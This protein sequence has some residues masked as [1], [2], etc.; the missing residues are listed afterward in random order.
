MLPCMILLCAFFEGS[1]AKHAIQTHILKKT[2]C[3]K[4]CEQLE[5][6][7]FHSCWQINCSSL[8]SKWRGCLHIQV[9]KLQNTL[10][11]TLSF[12]AA[13]LLVQHFRSSISLPPC[14]SISHWMLFA[15]WCVLCME[16]FCFQFFS[17]KTENL[18]LFW[19]RAH[20]S[21]ASGC[22]W[23]QK[24]KHACCSCNHRGV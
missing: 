4:T 18:K 23:K 8:I 21:D 5:P 12:P 20:S 15:C 2:Q 9:F 24:Q 19:K 14:H 16:M 13:F 10:Q 1:T 22:N 6:C 17:K 11:W 3:E 7:V